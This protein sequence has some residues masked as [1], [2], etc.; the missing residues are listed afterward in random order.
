[1]SDFPKVKKEFVELSKI[2][3]LKDT[4]TGLITGTL[5]SVGLAV[6]LAIGTGED[7]KAAQGVSSNFKD[8]GQVILLH[9]FNG[10][11][12]DAVSIAPFHRSH[13]SHRSH[14]SHQSHYSSRW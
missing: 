6:G 2:D 4:T 13:Y 7:A 3:R 8:A 5:V 9:Q 12:S 10:N 11:G 14:M 1:M